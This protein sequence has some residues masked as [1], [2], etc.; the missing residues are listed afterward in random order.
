MQ[1]GGNSRCTIVKGIHCRT[2][3]N[4]ATSCQR[5]VRKWSFLVELSRS[6]PML[7]MSVFLLML[8]LIAKHPHLISFILYSI[9]AESISCLDSISPQFCLF[10]V[11]L[12][13]PYPF[14]PQITSSGP[15]RQH[16]SRQVENRGGG[17]VMLMHYQW[18]VS[19][20]NPQYLH[21]VFALV[22]VLFISDQC[23]Y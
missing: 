10:S 3:G 13:K 17:V 5:N 22:D 11:H 1:C 9:W 15:S 18:Q 7:H 8:P 23:N 19:I 14:P 20:M 21:F 4:V 6:L 16:F 2:S 12:I